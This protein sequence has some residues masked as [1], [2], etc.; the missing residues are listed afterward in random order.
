MSKSKANKDSQ[1]ETNMDSQAN[2]PVLP[3]PV[4]IENASGTTPID[5]VEMMRRRVSAQA[6]ELTPIQL[7]TTLDVFGLSCQGP[8]DVLMDRLVRAELRKTVGEQVADWNPEVDERN[9][10]PRTVAGWQGEPSFDEV[11]EKARSGQL[12]ISRSSAQVGPVPNR[13]QNRRRE[14]NPGNENNVAESELINRFEN[15]QV[16]PSGQSMGRFRDPISFS[17]DEEEL[18]AQYVPTT[19]SYPNQVPVSGVA[20]TPNR[21][22]VPTITF[23]D[24]YRMASSPAMSNQRRG[25]SSTRIAES[26]ERR[27]QRYPAPPQISE[28]IPQLPQNPEQFPQLPQNPEQFPQLPQI[29]EQ[30]PQ[31]PPVNNTSWFK[32][33]TFNFPGT[34]PMRPASRLNLFRDPGYQRISDRVAKIRKSLSE[35]NIKF[36]GVVKG[37]GEEYLWRLTEAI[38]QHGM[39]EE[40]TMQIIPFTLELPA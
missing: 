34:R 18:G 16:L 15:I 6:R 33:A 36:S 28:P 19:S 35:R 24:G 31:P 10:M 12:D 20:P 14:F 13:E 17:Q 4:E 2:N 38:R 39:T 9:G 40:E 5:E 8:T 7:L 37:G 25:A 22:R 26:V 32:N 11:I 29:P 3:P 1:A 30:L 21:G 27:E 23:A